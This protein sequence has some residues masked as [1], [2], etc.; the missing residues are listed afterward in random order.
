MRAETSIYGVSILC[1]A[2]YLILYRCSFLYSS[3]NPVQGNIFIP[4]FR[5]QRK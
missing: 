4:I 3:Y 5:A 1:Q 2:L